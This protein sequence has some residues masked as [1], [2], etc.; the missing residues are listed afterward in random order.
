M[1]LQ[2]KLA[3]LHFLQRFFPVWVLKKQS[4]IV[5]R[6]FEV[7]LERARSSG[8][9]E[10]LEYERY[11]E[12]SEY[13]EAIQTIHSRRLMAQ[14]RELFIFIPDLK[15]EE[16]KWGGH[17]LCQES[18]SKLYHAVKAQRDSKRE[19][20]IRIVTAATGMIGALIGLFAIWKR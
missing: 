18:L 16:G 20:R 13:D 5:S 11:F 17:F 12:L 14:A 6:S 15:W 1:K 19:Y 3:L 7:D 9:R 2:T 10:R 8:D 4:R